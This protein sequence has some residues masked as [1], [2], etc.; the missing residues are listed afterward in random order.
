MEKKLFAIT[1]SYTTYI[2]KIRNIYS[3]I[4]YFNKGMGNK[5]CKANKFS[6]IVYRINLLQSKYQC[7]LPGN[8]K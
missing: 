4:Q 3:G 6:Q 5:I 7:K 1:K 2:K 8:L